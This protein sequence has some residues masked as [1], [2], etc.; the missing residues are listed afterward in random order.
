MAGSE[1][2]MMRLWDTETLQ[3]L[4]NSF[5]G[6][7]ESVVAM[8][9]SSDGKLVASGAADG[10]VKVWQIPFRDSGEVS[11][12][13]PV[14]KT[15]GR[16]PAPITSVAFNPDG[17]RVVAASRDRA[18]RV[19]DAGAGKIESVLL[20]GDPA[21][22]AMLSPDGQYLVTVSKD[23]PNALI[24]DGKTGKLMRELATGQ[25]YGLF[26]A[27]FSPDGARIATASVD[28]NIVQFWNAVTG[29]AAGEPLTGHKGS[30]V[31]VKYSQDGKR[32]VT[33][34]FDATAQQ[35]DAA[36]GKPIGAPLVGRSS[37]VYSAEFSPDGTRIVTAGTEKW[38]RIWDAATSKPVGDPLEHDAHINSVAF[39]PDGTYIVTASDDN[40]ARLWIAATGEPYGEPLK[41]Y[42][43]AVYG[44]A[45]SPDGRRVVTASE[46]GA[47]RM[48]EVSTG[49]QIGE[50]LRGDGSEVISANY[51]P[52]GKRIITT[53][54]GENVR[55][56]QMLALSPEVVAQAK[57]RVSRCLA[58]DER[59]RFFLPAE[60]PRWCITGAGKE[61]EKDAAKW[62]PKWPYDGSE[63]R[64]WLA[65][66]DAGEVLALPR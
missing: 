7:G 33:G 43:G 38:A 13:A 41:G 66:R 50:P 61:A 47:V 42:G 29:K 45:F 55:F 16:H 19:W 34:S 32:I 40:T 10:T 6:H 44:A 58:K 14:G 36:T 48:W 2:G 12:S 39:S 64:N 18:A 3:P 51:S 37:A 15:L 11:R 63:W 22:R 28:D 62:I 8:A 46:D 54:T 52:D 9:F 56:W 30:I 4:G 35:W 24:R 5:K 21:Y 25:R 57:T 31:S 65:R 26:R 1:D 53:S 20:E 60:P 49:M 17:T 23:S 59:E 27:I